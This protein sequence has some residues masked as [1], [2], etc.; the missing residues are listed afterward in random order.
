MS[1][2][3]TLSMKQTTTFQ[4][5]KRKRDF[6]IRRR[7]RNPHRLHTKHVT[8]TLHILL[9]LPLFQRILKQNRNH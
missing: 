9:L 2:N 7:T 3:S 4:N 8:Q 6:C 1:K 5:T